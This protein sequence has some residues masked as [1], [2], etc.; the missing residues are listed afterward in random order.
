MSHALHRR[1]LLK[2]SAALLAGG[3]WAGTLQRASAATSPNELLNLALIGIGNQGANNL[4]GVKSQ[5]IVALCDVDDNLVG[6]TYEKFPKAKKFYDFRE[7]FDK[8]EK[9]IDGVVVSTP[10]HTH[11]HPAYWT[12]ERK[13]HLYLEKP[14]C[15]SVWETRKITDMAREKKVATQLGA[16]RHAMSSLREGVEI[17]RSGVL[18]NIT[19][20]HSWVGSDRGMPPTPT[21]K[22]SVPD[23]LKWDLWLG[24]A[25]ERDYYADLVPYKWRFW[26]DFGT[27][28]VGNWGCHILDIPFWALEL[29]YPTKVELT[30]GGEP[31]LERTPKMMFCKFSFPANEKRGPISLTWG[32]GRPSILDEKGFSA[33]TTK[34]MN[35]LFIGSEGML[36][37]GFGSWKLF[38]E[39]K[40]VNHKAPKTFTPSPGFHEEWF[41]ACRGGEPATCHFDYSGPLTETAL[42]TNVAFRAKGGFDWDAESLK[43]SGN[44]AA[45]QFLKSYFR[46][47]WEV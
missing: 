26:W 13:K 8:M 44:P 7:M 32:Q 14:M 45:E 27:G 29:K 5:N 38:P 20:V 30:A 42:L 46:K 22:P 2:S 41:N 19:E 1:D 25:R 10:D 43:V 31:D 3:V 33:S 17:V 12:L 16:Q 21:G 18:G 4:K 28:D 40:F 9:Q 15:H 6:G 47:G 24:P 35:N 36:L 34:G 23:T 39:S 11:F 37:T